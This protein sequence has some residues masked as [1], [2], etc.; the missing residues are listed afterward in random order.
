MAA[1][2]ANV[3]SGGFLLMRQFCNSHLIGTFRYSQLTLLADQ[4]S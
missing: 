3:E 1:A 2:G 4:H